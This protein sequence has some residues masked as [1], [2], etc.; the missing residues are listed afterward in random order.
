MNITDLRLCLVNHMEKCFTY[1]NSKSIDDL[2]DD[3]AKFTCAYIMTGMVAIKED[4]S[5]IELILSIT[6]KKILTILEGK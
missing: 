4:M 5:D 6:S 2:I 3:Q 1:D